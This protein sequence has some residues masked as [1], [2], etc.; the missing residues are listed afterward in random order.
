M[1]YLSGRRLDRLES[2][3]ADLRRPT[4]IVHVVP[5]DL[6]D[7]ESIAQATEMFKDR[8]RPLDVLINNA[9]VSQRSLAAD[10]KV[11]VVDRVMEVNFR[12]TI[13]LTYA[14]LPALQRSPSGRVAVI[15]SVTGL[16]GFPMRSAYAASKHALQGFFETMQLESDHPRITIVSPGPVHTDISIS[17]LGPDGRPH[18]QMDDLQLKGLPLDRAARRILKAVVKGEPRLLLGRSELLLVYLHR[19]SP[20]IFHWVVKRSQLQ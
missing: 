11:E 17:A 15:S 2:L 14:L 7:V 16:F 13:H 5:L 19:F 3:A 20:R 18:G 12:G 6:A 9:G 1:L 10:T 8:E 4:V